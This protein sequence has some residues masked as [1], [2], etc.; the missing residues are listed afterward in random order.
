MQ[1]RMAWLEVARA[2]VAVAAFASCADSPTLQAPD[3]GALSVGADASGREPALGGDAGPFGFQ[4]DIY[5]IFL[6]QCS[7]CHS[8]NG[9][10]HDIASPDRELAYADAVEFADRIVARIQQGNMPPSCVFDDA[11][12][13]SASDLGLIQRWVAEAFPP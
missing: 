12:C 8:V 2:L 9:P 11:D 3:A 4:R 6:G 1:G 13:V 10:Y 7:M 5:P